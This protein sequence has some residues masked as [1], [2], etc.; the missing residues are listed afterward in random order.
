FAYCANFLI[1]QQRF[2]L[3]TRDLDIAKSAHGS[4]ETDTVDMQAELALQGVGLSIVD[5]SVGKEVRFELMI[6]TLVI[7]ILS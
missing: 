4:W 7:G 2:M 1:G 6:V 3:F 5:N